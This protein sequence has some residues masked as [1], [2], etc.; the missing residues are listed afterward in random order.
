MHSNRIKGLLS[1]SAVVCVLVA[2][3]VTLPGCGEEKPA[4]VV[5]EDQAAVAERNKSMEDYMKSKEG[6]ASTKPK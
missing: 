2:W 5:P 4:A 1:V 6:K 3:A